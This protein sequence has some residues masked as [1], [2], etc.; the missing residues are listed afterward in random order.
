[1]RT[2]FFLLCLCSLLSGCS[3]ENPTAETAANLLVRM[4][5]NTAQERLNNLG[6]PAEIPP[7]NAAQTPTLQG[8]SAHYIELSPD[9]ATPLGQGEII[10]MGEETT[11]GGDKAI[12]FSQARI[13][14]DNQ[15]FMELP[16]KNVTPGTYTW[17]R[18]SISYQSGTIDFLN[19]GTDLQGAVA[20]FLGYNSYI[21][22]VGINGRTVEV[23][24]NKLQGFWVFETLGLTFTG[25]APEGAVTVPNPLFETSP[26][27]QGSCVITGK[28]AEPLVI[29]GTESSDITINL[30][31][32]INNSFEW[33]EVNTD[34]KYEPNAGEQLADM[35]LRGLIPSH[36]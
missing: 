26:I 4:Q 36:E 22:S 3:K 1:M 10:Y 32:S 16:L 13:V 29:T 14:G 2:S 8:M 31:F 5:F 12:D 19:N 34:G 28:F 20:S 33:K 11:A 9:G 25:Q 15:T 23:N 35:G 18:V 21:E 7:G 30:S 6:Q 27:P 24:A 17:V